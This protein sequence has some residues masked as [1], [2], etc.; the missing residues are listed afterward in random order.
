MS[1]GMPHTHSLSLSRI[2]TEGQRHKTHSILSTQHKIGA[3]FRTSVF[4]RRFTM[5]TI[6]SGTDERP[7]AGEAGAG[8][9]ATSICTVLVALCKKKRGSVNES[10]VFA[11][12]MYGCVVVYVCVC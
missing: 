6:L 10:R 1:G 7:D 2:R 3:T 12:Y 5:R 4:D 11:G 8:F 9:E